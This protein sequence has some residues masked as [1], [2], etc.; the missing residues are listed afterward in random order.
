MNDIKKTVILLL[1]VGVTTGFT[2]AASKEGKPDATLRL[3]G[4]SLA[5]GIGFSWGKVRSPT[6]AKTIRFL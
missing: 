4:G 3:S 2:H 5:A 1:V 6:R